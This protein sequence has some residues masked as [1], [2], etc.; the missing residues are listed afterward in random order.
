MPY[1]TGV[2]LTDQ[3]LKL[4]FEAVSQFRGEDKKAAKALLDA[5]ILKY[6]AKRWTGTE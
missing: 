4:H 6:Q 3:V 1:L 5:L 2:T